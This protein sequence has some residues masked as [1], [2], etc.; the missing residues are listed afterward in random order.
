MHT[1]SGD[2]NIGVPKPDVKGNCC[3]GFSP[4]AMQL[5]AGHG[6]KRG[7]EVRMLAAR[8]L[9]S[10]CVASMARPGVF[11]SRRMARQKLCMIRFAA[12]HV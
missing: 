12:T 1:L 8:G 2:I 10:E 5:S 11:N 4:V 3:S 9:D 6:E 7:G